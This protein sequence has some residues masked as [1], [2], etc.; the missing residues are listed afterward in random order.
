MNILKKLTGMLPE[1]LKK[2]APALLPSPTAPQATVLSANFDYLPIHLLF[3]DVSVDKR[4]SP[5]PKCENQ[6]CVLICTN[7]ALE[8][9]AFR[10]FSKFS[11]I[12]RKQESGLR[13]A[14]YVPIRTQKDDKGKPQPDSLQDFLHANTPVLAVAK[15][16]E[17]FSP[18]LG[19]ALFSLRTGQYFH[20]LR[21]S[22]PLADFLVSQYVIVGL[23]KGG[24]LRVFDLATL[25]QRCAISTIYLSEAMRELALRSSLQSSSEVKED[26]P[27]IFQFWN[28]TVPVCDVSSHLIAYVQHDIVSESKFVELAK[29]IL[30]TPIINEYGMVKETA[31]K[32]FELGAKGYDKVLGIF[33]THQ[34]RKLDKDTTQQEVYLSSSSKVVGRDEPVN[35]KAKAR[36]DQKARIKEVDE[37]EEDAEMV[38]KEKEVG[39]EFEYVGEDFVKVSNSMAKEAGNEE[40]NRV[41]I[42]VKRMADNATLATITPPYFNGI[43]LLKFSPSGSLLLVANESGQYFYLYKLFPETNWRHLSAQAAAQQKAAMLVYSIFRGYTSAKVSDVSFSL[44]E[45]WLI[46]N[47]AK[48][49]SHIYRLDANLKHV[50]GPIANNTADFSYAGYESFNNRV[51]NLSA[52]SRFK[53]SS[54]IGTEDVSPV[55]SIISHY[56]LDLLGSKKEVLLRMGAAFY[57]T[58]ETTEGGEDSDIPLFVSVTRE[59]EVFTNALLIFHSAQ[60]GDT[61]AGRVSEALFGPGDKQEYNNDRLEVYNIAKFQ[62][63]LATRPERLR[64]FLDKNVVPVIRDRPGIGKLPLNEKVERNDSPVRWDSE[65]DQDVKRKQQRWLKEIVTVS[66][67]A[68]DPEKLLPKFRLCEWN[69]GECPKTAVASDEIC[70]TLLSRELP[71]R[72]VPEQK[73]QQVHKQATSE[74]EESK[75]LF[76]EAERLLRLYDEKEENPFNDNA[77]DKELERCISQDTEQ[78]PDGQ[79]RGL[80]NTS[81]TK[82]TE[83]SILDKSVYN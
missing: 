78:K 51:I 3:P 73:A 39:D 46:V 12:F 62:L 47:S 6:L 58:G 81:S 14:R 45:N 18:T 82:P 71:Y 17:E 40:H 5:Q 66:C 56:P 37:E 41:S 8:V 28:E 75:D 80:Q 43:S 53:Y 59:G 4:T 22:A 72:S 50:D 83:D 13:V 20:V 9:W 76:G 23:L 25:E 64:A 60:K 36:F 1:P 15:Q 33:N 21:F 2:M 27:E 54:F 31:H 19:I 67:Y 69:E 63:A 77:S 55:T 70:E 24:E 44:C 34:A 11:R 49:T 7:I 79:A 65:D 38:G 52:F 16:L 74:A 32:L 26:G 61:I 30:G 68:E 42:I 35:A 29:G 48:G 57:R 10:D